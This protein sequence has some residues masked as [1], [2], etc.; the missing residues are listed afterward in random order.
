MGEGGGERAQ[1]IM[2]WIPLLND[3]LNDTQTNT[4][5]LPPGPFLIRGTFSEIREGS[6]THF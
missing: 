5:K 1:K 2:K 3:T 4:L 6:T